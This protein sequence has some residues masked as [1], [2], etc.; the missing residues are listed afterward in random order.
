[1]KKWILGISVVLLILLSSACGAA[2]NNDTPD[3]SV[4]K[5]DGDLPVILVSSELLL[6]EN[7]SVLKYA[8]YLYEG[9]DVQFEV[10]PDSSAER[11]SRLSRLR[12]EIMSGSGPDAFV[13]PCNETYLDDGGRNTPLFENV[14]KAMRLSLFLPLDELIAKSEYLNMEEHHQVIM[15]AG[16]TE[17]GQQVLPLLFNCSA[18]FVEGQLNE[19]D[20]LWNTWDDVLACKD[21]NLLSI[22]GSKRDD[23]FGRQYTRFADY[24]SEDLLIT[25]EEISRDMAFHA[26]LDGYYD[27]FAAEEPAS[28]IDI[29]SLRKW[30]RHP[31]EMTLVTVPNDTGGLTATISA[32]AAINRNSEHAEEVFKLIELLF[33]E[34]VQNDGGFSIPDPFNAG[35]ERRYGANAQPSALL[36]G[37]AHG[38][39]A[40]HKRAYPSEQGE[41]ICELTEKINAV[42]FCSDIEIELGQAAWQSHD[43]PGLLD[44][45]EDAHERLS[46]MLSE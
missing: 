25:P 39:L 3:H 17:E 33:A 38:G 34:E 14:E 6:N 30:Q 28:V 27:P 26:S 46:M 16:K 42:R 35:G 10:L 43:E 9:Y 45:A 24:D 22:L 41:F 31:E 18:Y 23:W 4:E 37:A 2:H 29:D 20:V 32:Y 44:A 8:Q 7:N 15:D 1:M 11:E 40:T 19:T 36:F 12:V 13:L 5:N 21:E